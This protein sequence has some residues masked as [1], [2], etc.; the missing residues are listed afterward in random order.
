MK[1]NWQTFRKQVWEDRLPRERRVIGLGAIILL[2]L[3]AYFILWQPAHK[4]TIKLRSVLPVMRMQA[5]LMEREADEV[6]TLRQRPQPAVLDAVALKNIVD[7]SAT[8]SQ[9]RQAMDQL[10]PIEPNSVRIS[11]AS[12][13]YVQWLHW[14]HGLQQEQHI[15]IDSLDISSLPSPGM[16]KISATLINGANQ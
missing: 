12:V 5:A 16:V 7:A 15:R 14:M 8:K 1:Q 3:L 6:E 9:L 13:P 4:A 2:P 10:A 11:F